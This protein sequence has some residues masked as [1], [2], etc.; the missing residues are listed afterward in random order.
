MPRAILD[1]RT[2]DLSAL[3]YTLHAQFHLRIYEN[4]GFLRI[5]VAENGHFLDNCSRFPIPNFNKLCKVDTVYIGKIILA[6]HNQNLLIINT[7]QQIGTA[8]PHS[9]E[10]SK[11]EIANKLCIGLMETPKTPIPDM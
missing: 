10:A 7:C 6:L 11:I 4:Y 3:V 5:N 9:V 2:T 1:K 8:Q